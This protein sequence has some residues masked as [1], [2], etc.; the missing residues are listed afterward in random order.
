MSNLNKKIIF[1]IVGLL[2]SIFVVWGFYI[3]LN[4]FDETGVMIPFILT[5][6]IVPIIFVFLTPVIVGAIIMNIYGF[7]NKPVVWSYI[8]GA[9]IGII[10][11]LSIDVIDIIRMFKIYF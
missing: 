5:T 10:I 11:A 9:T 4:L 6:L 1:F 3:F 8:I 2:L 7:K